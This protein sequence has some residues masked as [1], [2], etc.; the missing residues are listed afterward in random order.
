MLDVSHNAKII[1]RAELQKDTQP[2][3]AHYMPKRKAWV[4]IPWK[5]NGAEVERHGGICFE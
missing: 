1:E 2:T 3:P 5:E 4:K